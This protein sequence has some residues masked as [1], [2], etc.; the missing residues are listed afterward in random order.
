MLQLE[1]KGLYGLKRERKRKMNK[2]G[3]RWDRAQ[4]REGAHMFLPKA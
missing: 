1:M 4:S 3:Q 2:K